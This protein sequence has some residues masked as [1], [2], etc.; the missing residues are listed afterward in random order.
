MDNSKGNI[1]Y[2]NG[3]LKKSAKEISP[4]LIPIFAILVLATG[5][6]SINAAAYAQQANST[7]G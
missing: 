6:T 3:L 5:F 4:F 1:Y 2:S 7:A